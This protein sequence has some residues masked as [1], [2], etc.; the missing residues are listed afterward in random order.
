MSTSV[1]PVEHFHSMTETEGMGEN[2]RQIPMKSAGS[3]DKNGVEKT[4]G[5]GSRADRG[6]HQRKPTA[7]DETAWK[8]RGREDAE[9]GSTPDSER[10][11]TWQ[12]ARNSH[13]IRA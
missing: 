2:A 8:V 1:E 7:R 12:R 9:D 6:K 13:V 5:Q 4:S 3:L 11:S 10:N